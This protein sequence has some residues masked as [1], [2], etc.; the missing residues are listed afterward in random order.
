MTADQ[1]IEY[2]LP[3]L[4]WL[5]IGAI[6]GLVSAAVAGVLLL[7]GRRLPFG[8]AAWASTPPVILC[9]IATLVLLS[10]DPGGTVEEQAQRLTGVVGLRL[11]LFVFALPPAGILLLMAAVAGVRKGPRSWGMPALAL[12]LSFG[13][14][15]VPLAT[16]SAEEDMAFAAVR[17]VIYGLCGIL[18]AL[19][20]ASKDAKGAE[21]EAGAAAAITL[22]VIVAAG[23]AG[24]R[25][26]NELYLLLML[27][28]RASSVRPE[29]V[30]QV[31]AQAVAPWVTSGWITLG[32]AILVA[33]VGSVLAVRRRGGPSIA[34]GLSAIL[35]AC[36]ALGLGVPSQA[37][38]VALG[39]VLPH[40][41][42]PPSGDEAGG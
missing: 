36:L 14:A 20:W 19:S 24:S 6:L 38:Y 28:S 26:L 17:A 39:E 27:P 21:P 4:S 30:E 37:D 41:D 5:V 32:V 31:M 16:G 7:K 9:V 35:P 34:I 40:V 8:V 13:V 11:L 22:P 15:A 42:L 2:L 33:I 10:S 25:A 23:E 1:F 29:I 18:V 12:V 3:H